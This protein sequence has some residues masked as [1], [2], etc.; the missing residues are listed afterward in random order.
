MGAT[1]AIRF[2]SIV[3][4]AGRCNRNGE[5]AV[6]G[7]VAVV[8]LVDGEG[9]EPRLFAS[10]VYDAFLLSQTRVVL[11]ACQEFG[12]EE[13]DELVARYYRLVE[14]A[15]KEAPL[16]EDIASG[17]WGEYRPLI[18]EQKRGQATLIVDRD[19]RQEA[20]AQEALRV[21]ASLGRVERRRHVLRLL[22]EHAVQVREGLL[23]AWVER[24]GVHTTRIKLIAPGMWLLAQDEANGPYIEGVGFVPVPVLDEYSDVLL[25]GGR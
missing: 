6:R 13:C 14:G 16:F 2:D 21:E 3:Q 24:L 25:G 15:V 17:A 20:M 23:R 4:V 5:A 18:E 19:G 7:D 12:E 11:D 8:S 9:P 22:L 10:Q 1:F